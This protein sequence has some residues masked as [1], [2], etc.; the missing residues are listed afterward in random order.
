[1]ILPSFD[2]EGVL[3]FIYWPKRKR[4]RGDSEMTINWLLKG[5]Q[6]EERGRSLQYLQD[7]GKQIVKVGGSRQ[8]KRTASIKY[9]FANAQPN[10]KP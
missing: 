6:G 3:F 2:H 7:V 10:L 1:M 5:S 4:E 9:Y 8:N